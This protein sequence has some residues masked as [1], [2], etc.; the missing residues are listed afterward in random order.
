MTTITIDERKA[1][2]RKAWWTVADFAKYTSV[3][4]WQAKS[5]LGRYNTE[6]GGMLLRPSTGTNRKYGFYWA[7]L[8]RHAPEA[9]ID[10]PI[11]MQRRLDDAE[12]KLGALHATT[13]MLTAATGQNSRD[14]ARIRRERKVA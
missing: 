14:I 8:A 7:L 1:M 13:K 11:E 12:D 9:F 5:A 10:D 4:H 3:S 6:L 2:R